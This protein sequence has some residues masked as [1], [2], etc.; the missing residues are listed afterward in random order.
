MIETEHYTNGIFHYIVQQY[1]GQ[2]REILA[3]SK[4]T[5]PVYLN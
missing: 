1:I 3:S 4:Y 2:A 5:T